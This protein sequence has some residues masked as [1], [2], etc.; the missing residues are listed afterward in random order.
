M[1]NINNNPS[2]KVDKGYSGHNLDYSMRFTSSTGMLLPVFYD[3]LYPNDKVR[4]N[5]N[6]ITRTMDL[7]SAAFANIHEDIDYF[8]VPLTQIYSQFDSFIYGVNDI[9]SSLFVDEYGTPVN[10]SLQY[11][12]WLMNF[13][14]VLSEFSEFT[15]PQSYSN[16]KEFQYPFEYYSEVDDFG[17]PIWN[18]MYRLSDLLRLGV[19]GSHFAANFRDVWNSVLP[20][21]GHDNFSFNLSVLAAYQKVFYDFYRDTNYFGTNP[22]SYNL[23]YLSRNEA[24]EASS[25]WQFFKL[26]Y[27]RFSNDFVTNRFPTP[28]FSRDDVS[29]L[30]NQISFYNPQ[31]NHQLL[32]DLGLTVE[33]YDVNT[34]FNTSDIRTAFAYEKYLE[35][36]RRVSKHYGSLTQARF[37]ITPKDVLS[38]ECIYIGSHHSLVS[39]Q[40]V[41]STAATENA[42][43]GEI[44]GKGYSFSQNKP[45]SFKAPCHGIIIGIYSAYPDAYYDLHNG[46]DRIH[47]YYY[48]D[49][50][51]SPEYD[52]IG[53]QPMSGQ[54]FDVFSSS[55]LGW[56]YRYM[57][58]KQKINYN[59]GGF[60]DGLNYW[61][62]TRKLD[63]SGFVNGKNNLVSPYELDDIMLVKFRPTNDNRPEYVVD[64]NTVDEFR[65]R[66]PNP[67]VSQM[68]ARDPLIH[69]LNFDYKKVSKMSTYSLPNL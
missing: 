68:Y 48:K 24:V 47:K 38:G 50:Y 31:T 11:F 12:P 22:N 33:G 13:Y 69:E 9:D 1:A 61:T 14:S 2:A 3:L 43:L 42:N 53:M 6:L 5:E 4:I 56:Q 25:F 39:I 40:Q 7:E 62:T 49:D 35:I 28:M 21:S 67:V 8:F 15:F 57:E 32:N 41:V 20:Q 55:V 30:G 36:N 64:T 46:I 29:A 51:Y 52:S 37:G 10:N 54:I 27:R 60:L 44:G 23:D 26:H 34:I 19:P 16:V 45:L 65:G 63:G 18:N 66:I 17:L 59:T 58:S